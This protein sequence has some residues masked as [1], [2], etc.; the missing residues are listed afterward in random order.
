MLLD[1]PVHR[2]GLSSL[3]AATLDRLRIA[4]LEDLA[5]L[6][7]HDLLRAIYATA[8]R[9]DRVLPVMAE[10]RGALGDRGISLGAID[11]VRAA[12]GEP[13][14]PL[15]GF[16]ARGAFRCAG[17]L[18]I[19]D[20]RFLTLPHDRAYQEASV[21]RIGDATTVQLRSLDLVELPVGSGTWDTYVR[22]FQAPGAFPTRPIHIVVQRRS[23]GPLAMHQVGEL[24]LPDQCVVFVDAE[25]ASSLPPFLAHEMEPWDRGLASFVEA[26]V[27]DWG[28]PCAPG[29]GHGWITHVDA[30]G[31]IARVEVT[32]YMGEDPYAGR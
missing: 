25:V 20:P 11:V 5:E 8:G 9:T 3:A 14:P 13:G 27:D 4:R 30:A 21:V 16:V 19:A 2:L 7:H 1:V 17:R 24:F 22:R 26:A 18:R 15:A 10:L 29:T 28:E 23:A 6:S 31:A 32:A 12:A